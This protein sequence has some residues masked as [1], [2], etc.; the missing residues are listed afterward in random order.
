MPVRPTVKTFFFQLHSGTLPVKPWLQ[1]KGLFVP[2]SINCLLCRKPETV[3]HIFLDCWDAVF[4]WDILQRTLKKD[5]PLTNYGIRFLS[6]DNEGGVPYDM[7]MLLGL[8]SL[9]R[10]RMAVRNADVNPRQA[11]EYLIESAI[12]VRE[13]YETLTEKPEW[14]PILDRLVSMKQF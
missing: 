2:W 5:L 7:F 9:W 6:V 12:Y 10:T 13:V 11:R 4:L 3:E 8:H 1:E 14:V